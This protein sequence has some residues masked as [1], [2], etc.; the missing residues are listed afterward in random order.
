MLQIDAHVH[1][2]SY[3]ETTHHGPLFGEKFLQE[4]RLAFPYK[5]DQISAERVPVFIKET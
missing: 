5:V 2:R 3:F 4:T 1:S